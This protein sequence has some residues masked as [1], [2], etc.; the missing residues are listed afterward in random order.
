MQDKDIIKSTFN[1]VLAP[2]ITM[3]IMGIFS[4]IDKYVK[5]LTTLK[6]LQLLIFAQLNQ[7]KALRLIS[8]SL[9]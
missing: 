2:I 6:L 9:Q 7:Y 3:Q 8:N 1:Q 5:K 4:E